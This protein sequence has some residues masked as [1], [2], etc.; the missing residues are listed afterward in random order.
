MAA[1]QSRGHLACRLSTLSEIGTSALYNTS[2]NNGGIAPCHKIMLRLKLY[3]FTQLL[4]ADI[5]CFPI[6]VFEFQKPL[7]C[8]NKVCSEYSSSYF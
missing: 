5:N 8:Q 4:S 6:T 1:E 2:V 3:Y 7:N